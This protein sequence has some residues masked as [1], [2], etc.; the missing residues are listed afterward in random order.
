MTGQ[1]S[2]RQFFRNVSNKFLKDYFEHNNIDFDVNFSFI[3]DHHVDV[4]FNAFLELDESIRIKVESDFQLI[5][6]LSTEGGIIALTDEAREFDNLGFLDKIRGIVGLHDKA[7]W[8]YIDSPEYWQAASMLF[9]AGSISST[10]WKRVINL[11]TL[12]NPFDE[13]DIKLLSKGIGE[14]FFN[15]EG[16]GKR[17]KVE[18]YNRN[19]KDY[20]YAFP[21]DFAK[22]EVEWIHDD[23]QSC[24]HNM[25]F[26]I[27]FEYCQE[28]ASLSIYARNNTKNI[29]QLQAL[30][31]EFILKEKLTSFTPLIENKVYNFEPLIE[32]DFNFVLPDES[33]IFSVQMLQVRS[34]C[35]INPTSHLTIDEDPNKNKN[36]VHERLAALGLSNNYITKVKIKVSF[37]PRPNITKQ[38]KQFTLSMPDKCNL[39]NFGDDKIIRD[40][41]IASGIEPQSLNLSLNLQ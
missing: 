36:A 32:A 33:E 3:R 16:R 14:Y 24:P 4:I 19:N 21:E 30:F 6:A 15:K 39:G 9:Q 23:L 40:M 2:T 26:E 13:T 11:P 22:S 34:T 17:C 29:P 12:K 10:L 28:E 37:F 35:K 5:Y 7:M 18:H 31:S 20:F 41:L 8:A 25:A 38:T 27:V 1:Y